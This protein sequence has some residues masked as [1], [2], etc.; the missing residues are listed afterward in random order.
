QA[1]V[2]KLA[3]DDRTEEGFEA[4]SSRIEMSIRKHGKRTVQH[5][6]TWL[7]DKTWSH[8]IS[9]ENL[10]VRVTP[11]PI[12]ETA[13][14]VRNITRPAEPAPAP[15]PVAVTPLRLDR[16]VLA[17]L[18]TP[19]TPTPTRRPAVT[20]TPTARIA[21]AETLRNENIAL[22]QALPNRE[23]IPADWVRNIT[24]PAE[25]APAPR[26]VAVTP[27]RLDRP[28]LAAL[29]TPNTPT[30]TRRPAVTATPTARIATA[31]TLRNENI[32][33]IQALPNR[34]TML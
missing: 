33:L 27:L 30:P 4:R 24:R 12:G 29:A 16:P 2:V 11:R 23:T 28:V 22:I 15:R 34:E 10:V 6:F 14:W 20:A 25:P 31:E 3:L 1:A 7:L 18:A 26:P 32:A 8:A 17:A 13:D 5:L 19:N 9:N 21:T